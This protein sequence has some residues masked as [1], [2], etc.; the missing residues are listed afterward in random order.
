MNPLLLIFILFFSACHHRVEILSVPQGAEIYQK[1]KFIGTTPIEVSNWWYPLQRKELE[2]HL[3][4]YKKF[5]F[6]LTYPFHR[7]PMDILFFRYD[8]MFGFTPLRHTII[9][10]KES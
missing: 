10:Q 9:L 7:V 1:N 2:I 4:G 6:R 3:I 5:P 8:I